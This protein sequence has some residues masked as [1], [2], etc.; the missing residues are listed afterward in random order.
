MTEDALADA[1]NAGLSHEK[2]GRFDE[3]EAAYRKAL[4]LDPADPGGVGVRLAAMGRGAAP[5]QAPE[6][7]VAMLFDQHAEVFDGILVDQLG[8]AVPMTTRERIQAKDLGPFDRMLDLGCGTGLAAVA[9]EDMCS[10]LTGADLAETMVEV[11]DDKDL[12]DDLYVAEATSFLLAAAEED[13]TWDLIV[14]T[15]VL[16]YIGDAAP[17]LGAAAGRLAPN[18]I[19]AFST[20]TLPDL[21]G[22]KVTPYHRYAHSRAYVEAE[23]GKV[24]LSLVEVTVIVVRH[25]EGAPLPGHL[26]LFGKP[27][28]A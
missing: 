18:G 11:S 14:A 1:Y 17:F 2:A 28:S 5:S 19:L 10:H 12:Y 24:G 27:G 4:A 6:A 8:Y 20:E 23:A 13:E 22:W 26:Y 9:L 3:A 7:Y 21:T 16:P 25:E 15:D